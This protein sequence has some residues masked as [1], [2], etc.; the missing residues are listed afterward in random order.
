VLTWSQALL[1]SVVAFRE[2]TV[3]LEVCMSGALPLG[4]D[5]LPSF[6]PR[7]R[8]R[9]ASDVPPSSPA[10]AKEGPRARAP[11]RREHHSVVAPSPHP[12]CT[13]L[14]GGTPPVKGVH[15]SEFTDRVIKACIRVTR[16]AESLPWPG[17]SIVPSPGCVL[18]SPVEP[19]PPPPRSR[20]GRAP[21]SAAAMLCT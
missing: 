3:C 11:T 9:A 16:R 15:L 8:P 5:S 18:R 19:P 7:L 17:A 6:L 13:P 14:C 20:Q 4:P 2:P 12:P 10:R 21:H 1:E